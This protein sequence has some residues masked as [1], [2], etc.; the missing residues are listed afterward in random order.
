[1]AKHLTNL[2][3]GRDE[4][5]PQEPRPAVDQTRRRRKQAILLVVLA[6]LV[7]L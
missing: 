1:M 4:I 5:P 2:G 6:L 3:L 7:A